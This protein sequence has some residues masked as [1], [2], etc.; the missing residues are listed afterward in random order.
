[1]EKRWVTLVDLKADVEAPN[2]T[3]SSTVLD[4]RYTFEDVESGELSEVAEFAESLLVTHGNFNDIDISSGYVK[5]RMASVETSLT[6]DEVREDF[7]LE[8]LA[9][10]EEF[11]K[12]ADGYGFVSDI[13]GGRLFLELCV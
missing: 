10:F 11:T 13:S 8:D 3:C 12:T 2:S 1:M 9:S 6:L 5:V 7:M 4:G